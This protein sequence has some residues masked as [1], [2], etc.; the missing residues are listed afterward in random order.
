MASKSKISIARPG[1]TSLRATIPEAIVQFLELKEG[2]ALEWQM[3]DTQE[4]RTATV[5]KAK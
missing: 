5:R 2:D 1:S 3:T 4:G